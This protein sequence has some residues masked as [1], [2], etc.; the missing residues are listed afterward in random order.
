MK[1]KNII[2]ILFVINS[3]SFSQKGME[4]IL[5]AYSSWTTNFEKKTID[6]NE[7]IAGGPPKD[8]IPALIDP[9]FTTIKGA[10]DWLDLNEPVIA[11]EINSSAKAYPLQI[12]MFHE[13]VN[14]RIGTVPL[15]VTFCP[16]CY[17]GLVFN[18]NVN[19][20][21]VKFGVTGLLRNSDLVMYDQLT[22]SFWQQFTGKSI[23]G[24]M[25]GEKLEV[26]SSQIISFGEF[27]NIY[28]NGLVLS[29]NTGFKRPYGKNPYFNY[30]NEDTVPF[31][32]TGEKD[33]RLKQNEKVIGLTIKDSSK[34]YPY[35]I[36]SEK[37]IIYDKLNNTEILIFHVP[38]T[39]SALDSRFINDSKDV[40]A[41][42]VFNP[43][44]DGEKLIFNFTDNKLIDTNTNSVWSIT[45]KCIS[46]KLKGEKLEKIHSGDYFA[47]AWLSFRP[48]SQIYTE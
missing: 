19:G 3:I 6:L 41:T 45:G 40:G 15:L 23:V 24:D 31:L 7:L 14:D 10:D 2:I 12:L 39:N 11:V 35:S 38:G 13:I 9:K 34:A 21:P 5:K 32:F 16:L 22:E 25:T 42:G 17:S 4:S 44:L 8:G 27:K 1:I 29:Q 43:Y 20:M 26:I 28:S 30:D 46:G 18:R 33:S 47:F 37:N 36:T 48:N